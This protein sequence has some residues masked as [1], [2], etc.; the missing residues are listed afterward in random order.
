MTSEELD[1]IE[2]H[3]LLVNRAVCTGE[4]QPLFGGEPDASVMR[5]RGKAHLERMACGR[6]SR[7]QGP[8]RKPCKRGAGA[9]LSESSDVLPFY[10]PSLVG[11]SRA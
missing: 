8:P 10:C 2:G 6:T 11:A 3:V 7:L 4:D 1:A 5:L 9:D